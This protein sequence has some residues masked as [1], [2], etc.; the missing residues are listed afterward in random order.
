MPQLN[1]LN[2][3]LL[4]QSKR[5]DILKRQSETPTPLITDEDAES[6]HK[7]RLKKLR[8]EHHSECSLVDHDIDVLRKAVE[9][10][11]HNPEALVAQAADLVPMSEADRLRW[12]KERGEV[13]GQLDLFVDAVATDVQIVA[14]PPLM[15]EKKCDPDDECKDKDEA[16]PEKKK[17]GRKPKENK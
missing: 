16:Q 11:G 2:N 8:K 7:K 1:A 14:E 17:R 13:E 3:I 5:K 10:S 6:E 15:I 12:D 9:I 4:R